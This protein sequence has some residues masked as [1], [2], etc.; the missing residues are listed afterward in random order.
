MPWSFK[1]GRTYFY[2]SIRVDG[3]PVKRYA[4]TGAAAERKA[5]EVETRKASRAQQAAAARDER[6]RQAEA[7]QPLDEMCQITDLLLKATLIG[8][9]FHQHARGA[10]RR[11]RHDHH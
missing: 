10:W 8:H 2:E 3:R 6:N 1:G 9:G 11:R 5:A 7:A 4:G